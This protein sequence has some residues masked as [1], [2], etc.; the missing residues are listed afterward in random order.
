FRE[1]MRSCRGSRNTARVFSGGRRTTMPRTQQPTEIEA[2][3]LELLLA[4][5][6][7]APG[8]EQKL[9]VLRALRGGSP[10]RSQR[11]D[12][13]LIEHLTRARHGLA[14]AQLIHA[15]LQEMLEH[16]AAPPWYPA[17]FLRAVPTPPGQRALV[18]YGGAR[19]LV[20][21]GEGVAL[22]SLAAGD[23]VFL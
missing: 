16:Q 17:L 4:T 14:Q 11:L 20:A 13:F 8:V 3:Q 6:D 19:R 7:G 2:A 5:G 15:Q 10:E 18:L 22:D 23:E 9:E 1:R 21:L 12:H